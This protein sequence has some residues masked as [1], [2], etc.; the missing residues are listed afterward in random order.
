MREEQIMK[1]RLLSIVLTLCML[2]T[3][4]PVLDGTAQAAGSNDIL[5]LE[6]VNPLEGESIKTP[7]GT[8]ENIPFLLEEENELL[9]Y[10]TTNYKSG[11]SHSELLASEY[12]LKK[13]STNQDLRSI[14]GDELN[15]KSN[16]NVYSF[17]NAVAFDPTC[18]GRKDHVAYIAFDSGY[19]K[20]GNDH[21]ARI[22]LWIR[23]VNT[24]A[25]SSVYTVTEDCGWIGVAGHELRQNESSNFFSITAGDYDGDGKDTLVIYVPQQ[26]TACLQQYEVSNNGTKI[27][28]S[29]FDSNLSLE[30]M[31]G[32]LYANL[33]NAPDSKFHKLPCSLTSCDFDGDGMDELA[34]TVS[35]CEW[36]IKDPTYGW[37]GYVYSDSIA[38][39]SKIRSLMGAYSTYLNIFDAGEN[40]SLKQIVK[41]MEII[42][43][44]DSSPNG[45]GTNYK[46]Q[47]MYGGSISSGDV[48]ADGCDE[49][50]L[51]GYT[52]QPTILS[53][54]GYASNIYDMD[55]NLLSV[56]VVSCGANGY[57]RSDISLV[58]MNAFTA[59]GFDND[60]D[61]IWPKTVSA[62]GYTNGASAAAQ[63][64]LDGTI[65][66]V[67]GTSLT[68]IY[69]PDYLQEEM[70]YPYSN[71]NETTGLTDNHIF[72]AESACIGSVAVGTFDSNN[73]GRQQFVF[74][75]YY[76]KD[77]AYVMKM[78]MMGGLAYDS[79][80]T[81]QSYYNS[82]LGYKSGTVKNGYYNIWDKGDDVKEGRVNFLPVAV[83]SDSDGVLAKYESAGYVYSDPQVQ[84]VLQAAPHFAELNSYDNHADGGTSYTV[85]TAY[86][87]G[88]TSSTTTSLSYG[89][90]AEGKAGAIKAGLQAG[91][92]SEFSKS[93]TEEYGEEYST[94]FTATLYDTVIVQ[95][96]PYVV[97]SYKTLKEG[98][99]T[100]WVDHA[101]QIIAPLKPVYFQLSV[102]DYNDIAERYNALQESRTATGKTALKTI[103]A[104][105]LPG[106]NGGNPFVYWGRWSDAGT[107]GA[108]LS[109]DSA[110]PLTYNGGSTTSSWTES[111]SYTE[112]IE[113]S[114][115]SHFSFTLGAELEVPGAG[116]YAGTYLEVDSSDT[117]GTYITK[118][119]AKGAYGTVSNLDEY[120]ML[121]ESGIP[122]EVTRSYGFN[123]SFGKWERD[124]N[125][126]ETKS[127]VYFFGYVVSGISAPSPCAE[128]LSVKIRTE[129][130]VKL[131]WTKPTSQ[132]GRPEISG[133]RVY[134]RP[135]GGKWAADT[136]Q[137]DQ[138]AVS[139]IVSG[140]DSDTDYEITVATLYED[141]AET[142]EGVYAIPVSFTTPKHNYTLSLSSSPVSGATVT[143]SRDGIA[144][145]NSL[146]PENTLVYIDAQA[147]EGYAIVGYTI[148]VQGEIEETPLTP[149]AST[150]FNFML[151]KDT[152]VQINTQRVESD[153]SFAS[154]DE[155]M[156][157]V[158]ATVGGEAFTSGGTVRGAVAFTAAPFAGNILLSW[159]V[160]DGDGNTQII[161]AVGNTLKLNPVNGPYTVSGNFAPIETELRT[162]TLDASTNGLV[163][164]RDGNGKQL[165][166]NAG[167]ILVPSNS[168]VTFSAKPD[169]YFTFDRWTGALSGESDASVTTT[170][171][172]NMT[173]GAEFYLRILYK[174]SYGVRTGSPVGSGSVVGKQN[175]LIF[176]PGSTV[177]GGST[178]AFQADANT[179]YRITGWYVDDKVKS[180]AGT[181]TQYS[182][183]INNVTTVEAGF[184]AYY[185]ITAS[186]GPGGRISPSGSKTYRSGDSQTY[187]ITP[188]GGYE[189]EDIKVN[190]SSVGK[191]TSH[192]FSNIT[193]NHTIS[194]TFTSTSSGGGVGGGG[195]VVATGYTLS[196]ETNGGSSISEVTES[197]RSTINL[198][199]YKPTKPGYTFAGW[200]SDSRLTTPVTSVKLTGDTTV[201][202]K[203]VKHIELFFDDVSED[204]Y[205]Y[206]AVLWAVE[207][208]VTDGT[209]KTTF[210][211]NKVCTRAQAVTFLW[212][213]SGSPE[214][215]A[216]VNPFTDVS[217]DAYYYKAV[218]WAVEKG[219]TKGA[220]ETTFNPNATCSRGQIVTFQYRMAGSPATGTVNPFTDVAGNA[221][222][223]DAVLWAVK[224]GITKGTSTTTFSPDADCT[225]AQIV[226]FLWRYLGK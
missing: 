42:D 83:D 141:G 106:N 184:E 47:M 53:S 216:T 21:N 128:N 95:R 183:V 97:H 210:G 168:E 54:T 212:R 105:D 147:A 19:V 98:S 36:M 185:T 217:A 187:T 74:M 27:S 133:F 64:F 163:E 82:V 88:Q 162:I 223:A 165:A 38:D 76:K 112:G 109:K 143:A 156:G 59:S 96:T 169:T 145:T 89:F 1:K 226:T 215:A 32:D 137:L 182:Q 192:D 81:V 140:L 52:G 11:G 70:H 174:V 149:C 146:C 90:S 121:N 176:L 12:T 68:P 26:A 17:A 127:P 101:Y 28:I 126:G 186:A 153:I 205:Y 15:V 116:G 100:E 134:T 221:Y 58:S 150:R 178:A 117:T 46:Y 113:Q 22:V 164:V 159:M 193:S 86:S 139:C 124:L 13:K 43:L 8:S 71:T 154:G 161:T 87:A 78:G 24:G 3:L 129:D 131:T 144:L 167:N 9:L 158:S 49:L 104:S 211:P 33:R 118:T 194:V 132:S 157:S 77:H 219:I 67:N 10:H 75:M 102:D 65:Y 30:Q 213:T 31:T 195:S 119:S 66:S 93:F 62:C 99:D 166:P 79:S 56:V 188:Y 172:E 201:Y 177:P 92:T 23:N 171:T 55:K 51:A 170:V 152:Q 214:P 224:E 60:V 120:T 40:G 2:A 110:Y 180:S 57:S 218:L 209:T 206:E 34:A 108:S 200:Y 103:T 204:D 198:T 138:D 73:S 207:H 179:G 115:G 173:V 160:A 5:S 155:T 35:S 220:T 190:G 48:N 142:G 50:I 6:Q 125:Q 84:A 148:S 44:V 91:S 199:T 72:I 136:A 41:K 4:L 63:V 25:Q 29:K 175:D 191:V 123:W 202:A 45:S 85:S 225:R 181:N 14:S 189:I 114:H 122:T 80:G 7:Y 197:S 18:S 107:G 39:E 61:R 130:S 37:S 203:W 196:F 208:G 222:Y 20:D 135:V 111:A 69:T 94:T 151:R 16:T